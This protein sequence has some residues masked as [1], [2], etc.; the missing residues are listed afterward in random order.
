[1]AADDIDGVTSPVPAAR[2]LHAATGVVVGFAATVTVWTAYFLQASI[3]AGGLFWD[4]FVLP[5]LAGLLVV[6]SV[7]ASLSRSWRKWWLGVAGG[8][9]LSVPLAI[10]AF[11]LLALTVGLG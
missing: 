7:S 4:V 2:P 5:I 6:A 1:M 10:A 8:V 11:V 3:G 9:L